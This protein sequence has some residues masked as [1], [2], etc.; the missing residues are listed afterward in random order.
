[1]IAI[2]VPFG[3]LTFG[4]K[5]SVDRFLF[6]FLIAIPPTLPSRTIAGVCRDIGQLW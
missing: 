4:K 2:Y 5:Q 1:V 3:L 6:Y